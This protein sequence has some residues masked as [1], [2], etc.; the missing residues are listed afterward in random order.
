MTSNLNSTLF[1]SSYRTLPQSIQNLIQR[2][3]QE[4]NPEEIILF[5]SR[6]RG[7]HRV[8]SDFDIAV[9]GSSIS[10]QAWTKLLVSLDDEPITLYQV[11]L[12][13]FEAMNDD[14]KDSV[15]SEGIT[16]YAK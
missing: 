15:T 12:L 1:S 14:Y 13:H 5:G 9:K 8:T 6:A 4:V 16:L 3:I 10:T 2:I 11:D 7:D